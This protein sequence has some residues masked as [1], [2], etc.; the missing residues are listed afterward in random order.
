MASKLYKLLVE[1]LKNHGC[2]FIREGKG[3]HEFWG[4]PINNAKFSVPITVVSRHTA[5]AI[6]KQA[7]I[8]EKI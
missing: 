5:N 6:L 4:S 8:S 2:Y 7:G 3:S 1:I